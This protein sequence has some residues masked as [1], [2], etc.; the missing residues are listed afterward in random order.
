[1]SDH[2]EREFEDTA[3]P[4]P[5]KPASP[6]QLDDTEFC[7]LPAGMETEQVDSATEFIPDAEAP[8]GEEICGFRD[9]SGPSETEEFAG[10]EVS[11]TEE[12]P[13]PDS[14]RDTHEVAV[15]LEDTSSIGQ[16]MTEPMSGALG[17][18]EAASPIQKKIEFSEFSANTEEVGVPTEPL[19]SPP[20][21]T[22]EIGAFTEEVEETEEVLVL[23]PD[24]DEQDPHETRSTESMGSGSS[25]GDAALRTVN[26]MHEDAGL[27]EEFEEEEFQLGDAENI[28]VIDEIAAL[29]TSLDQDILNSDDL[30]AVPVGAAPDEFPAHFEPTP[31]RTGSR[32]K[33]FVG[34]T[35]VAA[36]VMAG[37]Y[38]W[39]VISEKY[40]GQDGSSTRVASARTDPGT[41]PVG[42]SE[43]PGVEVS[44]ANVPLSPREVIRVR[45]EVKKKVVFALDLGLG[46]DISH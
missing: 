33:V 4:E 46:R 36:A 12:I 2:E 25:I 30:E 16:S 34:L 11:G 21:H 45:T 20:S 24:E 44:G 1:M 8:E 31:S 10:L 42:G 32:A 41:D 38:F 40:L 6:D 26:P 5:R 7:D 15:D 39:P 28:G 14:F 18:E 9:T 22:E 37:V 29:A 3:S 23:L 13:G 35:V 43:D 17:A 27:E 19:A